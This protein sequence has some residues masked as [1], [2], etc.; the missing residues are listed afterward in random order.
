MRKILLAFLLAIHA[1]ASLLAAD[2]SV[3]IASWN[4]QNLGPA[5]D[6]T[7]LAQVIRHFDIVALQ[8]AENRD[9]VRRLLDEI[10]RIT[11]PDAW[12]EITSDEVG[13]GGYAEHYAFIYRSDCVTYIEGSS[14]VY[15]ETSPDDFAREPFFATF[16]ADEFDFTLIAVH[17]IWGESAAARTRECERLLSVWEYVQE[18]DP[19]E[20]D[21]ILLGDFN[22]DRPTHSAFRAISGAGI[23]PLLTDPWTRTT[24]GRTPDG[25][26]WYDNIW[27]DPNHTTT[28]E[29]TGQVG[30]STPTLNSY[31]AGC[32]EDLRGASDHCPV[33]AVF[34][35]TH[36]DD[37]VCE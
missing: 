5:K 34:S 22:R 9:D 18:L 17:V 30:T 13:V 35:T 19:Y 20:N 29:Q 1:S 37:P 31:G 4:V 2:D 10:R 32:S 27:I 26:Y 7:S 21:L 16:R 11:A 12:K 15:P 23:V 36:D 28:S 8:E 14:G 24:F 3:I 25:G 6:V 33:W